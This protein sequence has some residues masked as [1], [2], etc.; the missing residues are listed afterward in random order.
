MNKELERLTCEKMGLVAGDKFK[1]KHA[2]HE[3]QNSY[4]N[5]LFSYNGLEILG[6]TTEKE[7]IRLMI[8]ISIG[9]YEIVKRDKRK[10]E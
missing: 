8:A 4:S 1:V 7:K 5:K 9:K 10:W 6:C 3:N 2:Q